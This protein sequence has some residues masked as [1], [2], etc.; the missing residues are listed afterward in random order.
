MSAPA[1][2]AAVDP[3][4]GAVVYEVNLDLDASIREAYLAWLA[5]HVAE[6]LS[7]P[8]FT[9]A[10]RFEVDDPAPAPGRVGLCVQYD[11]VDRAA[12]AAYLRDHAPRL[13]AEGQARFGGRFTAT[14][15]ILTGLA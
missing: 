6:V 9:G 2:G 1:A 15:R 12:L 11:L 7:L 13:R 10:R 3:A 4:A 14:R 5:D 8:G